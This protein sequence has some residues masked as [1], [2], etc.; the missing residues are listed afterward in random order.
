[1]PSRTIVTSYLFINSQTFKFS[2]QSIIVFHLTYMTQEKRN[3]LKNNGTVHAIWCATI[4][5]LVH[6]TAP[7]GTDTGPITHELDYKLKGM[8]TEGVTLQ[9]F[10][11]WPSRYFYMGLNQ[12][13]TPTAHLTLHHAVRSLLLDSRHCTKAKITN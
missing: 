13:V 9:L 6:A 3:F 8:A 7:V 4:C 10:K 5:L 12:I 1:M 11:Y 2:N